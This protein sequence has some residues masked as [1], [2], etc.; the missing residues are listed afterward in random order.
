MQSFDGQRSLW[1]SIEF[2]WRAYIVA[3]DRR[4]RELLVKIDDPTTDVGNVDLTKAE[5]ELSVQL[6]FALP[7]T[8]DMVTT[9]AVVRWVRGR[10][11]SSRAA[12]AIG[13]EFVDAPYPVRGALA[14]Y[15]ALMLQG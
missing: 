4:C 14:S 7:T 8:G 13:F 1:K 9:Q 15:V 2:Q 3:Q 12:S 11:G 10:N 6:R 5:D